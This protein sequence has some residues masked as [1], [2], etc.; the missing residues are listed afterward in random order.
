MR[1]ATNALLLA[2][3]ATAALA[4]GCG[5]GSSDGF[6]TIAEQLANCDATGQKQ[7]VLKVMQ[8][9]LISTNRILI[10]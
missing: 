1:R 2:A 10:L 4:S 6:G 3:F 5:G 9:H 7:E 8:D